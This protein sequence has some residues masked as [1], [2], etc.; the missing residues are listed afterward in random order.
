LIA[1][2]VSICAVIGIGIYFGVKFKSAG[3]GC[4]FAVVAILVC[5]FVLVFAPVCTLGAA[6]PVKTDKEP[7]YVV[8]NI[9][10]YYSGLGAMTRYDGRVKFYDGD[11]TYIEITHY[12]STYWFYPTTRVLMVPKK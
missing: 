10:Y 8:E 9:P 1:L 5:I 7:V 2:I 3:D 6:T 4:L 12:D 11:E